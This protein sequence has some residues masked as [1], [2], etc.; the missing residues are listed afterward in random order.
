MKDNKNEGITLIALVITILVV[1]IVS[2]ATIALILGAFG[3]IEPKENINKN[4]YQNQYQNQNQ[5]NYTQ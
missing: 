1:L 2:G 5:T 3:L 4:Q